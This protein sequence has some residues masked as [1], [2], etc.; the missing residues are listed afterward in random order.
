MA[1]IVWLAVRS[2]AATDDN[3]PDREA[4]GSVSNAFGQG[5]DYLKVRDVLPGCQCLTGIADFQK[6]ALGDVDFRPYPGTSGD[7]SVCRLGRLGGNFRNW[8]FSLDGRRH[9]IGESIECGCSR[10][11]L[12]GHGRQAARLDGL[13]IVV[14]IVTAHVDPEADIGKVARVVHLDSN[15]DV[16]VRVEVALCHPIEGSVKGSAGIEPT[17]QSILSRES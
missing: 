11:G 12:I 9:F 5:I 2:E 1:E 4:P 17:R 10:L 13:L 16:I 7:G 3:A 14:G 8:E 6:L 15:M